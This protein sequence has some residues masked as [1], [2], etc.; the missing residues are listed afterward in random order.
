VVKLDYSLIADIATLIVL[1]FSVYLLSRQISKDHTWKRR[2]AAQDITNDI[3]K[4]EIFEIRKELHK[5][6]RF[7]DTSETYEN[8]ITKLTEE[9]RNELDF[10]LKIYLSYFEGIGLGIKHKIYDEDILYEYMSAIIPDTFRW[11]K[12]YIDDLRDKAGDHRIF[13]ELI[14]LE[15]K[16]RNKNEKLENEWNKKLKER[17][18]KDIN[19]MVGKGKKPT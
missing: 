1:I 7:Y 4:G 11:S 10:L 9:E 17:K 6:A 2:K 18:E 12:K 19:D 16:W 14:F 15:T 8:V 5:F 3:M 13:C